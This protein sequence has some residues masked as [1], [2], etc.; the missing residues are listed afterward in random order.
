M[1]RN[2]KFKIN[3]KA[4]NDFKINFNLRKLVDLQSIKERY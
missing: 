1:W 2:S 3:F 4:R